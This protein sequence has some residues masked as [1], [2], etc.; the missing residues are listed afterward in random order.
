MRLLLLHCIELQR[1]EFI[2]HT[3]L[4]P[5]VGRTEERKC[6][7]D[8]MILKPDLNTTRR[9]AEQHGKKVASLHK[10]KTNSAFEKN[11]RQLT[12]VDAAAQ[13]RRP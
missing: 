7:S 8:A 5:A 3:Q 1:H 12:V 6:V 9:R 13:L 11:K 4:D 2:A 10:K